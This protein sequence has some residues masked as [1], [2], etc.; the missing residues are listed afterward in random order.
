MKQI[1]Y[2]R[3]V[4][5]VGY[6]SGGKHIR[7]LNQRD[8]K[9]YVAF[10][11]MMSRCY[12]KYTHSVYPTY[13]GCHVHEDWHDYQAFATWYEAQW[14]PANASL[15]KDLLIAGNKLYSA[16]TAMFLSNK[17]NAVFVG[18]DKLPKCTPT[19]SGKVRV[20]V[21]QVYGRMTSR[22][23]PN[24]KEAQLFALQSRMR[25][26]K[27][28]LRDELDTCIANGCPQEYSDKFYAMGVNQLALTNK[29]IAQVRNS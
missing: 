3:T 19:N 24:T 2:P 28:V 15:D 16:D 5:G 14:K 1:P 9:P 27:K 26:Y 17:V 29:L 13:I 7:T 22:V 12:S 6:D 25:Y 23:F 11:R 8:L 18:S 4:Q 21:K 10:S 20:G